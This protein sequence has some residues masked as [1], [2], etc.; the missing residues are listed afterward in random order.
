MSTAVRSSRERQMNIPAKYVIGHGFVTDIA[1]NH[2]ETLYTSATPTLGALTDLLEFSQASLLNEQITVSPLAYKYSSFLRELEWV[3]A[4]EI[5]IT[6]KADEEGRDSSEPTVVS[7]E[8]SVGVIEVDGD[9]AGL[10]GRDPTAEMILGMA[11]SE[12]FQDDPILRCMTIPR[13]L[14]PAPDLGV[15]Y[16]GK[17]PAVMFLLQ[18]SR[19]I[20]RFEDA[21]TRDDTSLR[22]QATLE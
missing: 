19:Q 8:S 16:G 15:F 4:P 7:E 1:V 2:M 13:L 5:R 6:E 11:F 14:R 9:E 20:I 21:A 10:F 12:L 17:L 3:H 22:L 18:I